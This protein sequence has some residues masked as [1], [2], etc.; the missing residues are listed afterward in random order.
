MYCTVLYCT[1]LSW[2]LSF[3]VFP[4]DGFS[5]RG[6][7]ALVLGTWSTTPTHSNSTLSGWFSTCPPL[8][9]LALKT[10]C[11]L[12]V[13]LDHAQRK[14]RMR[15]KDYRTGKKILFPK[16]RSFFKD[17]LG[18]S[19]VAAGSWKFQGSMAGTP[20]GCGVR[21]V[22]GDPRDPI[23]KLKPPLEHRYGAR[24]LIFADSK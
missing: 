24:L 17:T 21:M 8:A 12:F 1:V 7:A 18:P 10:D 3:N 2:S 16:E 20:V 15:A 4:R 9:V 14:T 19:G 6:C 13:L 5:G 11:Q 22:Y 23:E